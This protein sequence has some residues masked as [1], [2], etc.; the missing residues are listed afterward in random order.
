MFTNSTRTLEPVKE[1]NMPEKSEPK[2]AG[3]EGPHRRAQI[4]SGLLYSKLVRLITVYR[5]S[6]SDTERPGPTSVAR[7]SYNG[8]VYTKEELKSVQVLQHERK[9]M[10]DKAAAWFVRTLRSPTLPRAHY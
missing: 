1:L 2:T 4:F 7:K 10:S 8:P 9:T 3:V 6:Y 5:G